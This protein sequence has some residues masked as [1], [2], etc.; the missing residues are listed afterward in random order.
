MLK[1]ENK[2][3]FTTE[4][5]WDLLRYT[6]QDK[7]GENALKKYDDDYFT[8]I[9][10]QVL[11]HALKTFYKNQR[12][13]P[14]ETILRENVSALLTS[15]QYL[16]LVTKDEQSTIIG[17][18]KNMYHI[19]VK[20]GDII[21]E[22][23]KEFK[24][25][26]LLRNLVSNLDLN[27]YSAYE[28]FSKQIGVALADEDK[29][30]NYEKSF[31]LENV[32]ERQFRRQDR[33]TI[34]PTPFKQ[35]NNLTNA[36]GYEAGAI[37]V[38]LDKQKKGKTT[39]L[40]NAARGY[41]RMGLK[42]MIVDLENGDDN[43][44][45]RLEQSIMDI[46]KKTLLSGDKDTEIQRRFRKYKRIGGE[47][48]VLRKPALVT[49]INDIQNDMDVLYRDFG[50]R[51][52]ILIIDYAAKMKSSTYGGDEDRT[53][54]SNVYL[55]LGNLALKNDILHIWTANHVT[56][57]AAKVRQKT[58]YVGEDIAN[59]VDIVRHA[60]AIFGL[61]RSEPEEEAGFFRLEIVEQRDGQPDG[62]A[63]FKA[64]LST[65]R[66]S[67]LSS[68]ERHVYDTEFYKPFVEQ[69]SES[70]NVVSKKE[71]KDRKDDFRDAS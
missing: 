50:F 32:K 3:K 63:V 33:K 20:D 52:D 12:R 43:I 21:Y 14:G 41:L 23:C 25:Y 4:Y 49:D 13:I 24:R 9:E 16:N 67:E 71:R 53:R 34:F 2:F 17:L 26:V 46:D 62:R 11:A 29:M 30:Q 60:Q 66:V 27:N 5:Q 31:L 51:P 58:K 38:L 15:K 19:P 8:L 18:I 57:E 61:N 7:N 22:N 36:G 37:L 35:I 47:V 40:A 45:A 55:E 42:I 64:N 6:V 54:I 68:N 65:Q 10:H 59:C 56:R 39:M 28:Q 69:Q 70:N 48:V 1:P 44:F